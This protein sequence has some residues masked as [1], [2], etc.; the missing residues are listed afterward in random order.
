VSDAF[1]LSTMP[2]RRAVFAGAAAM[3]MSPGLAAPSLAQTSP[4]A[5]VAAALNTGVYRFRIGA[6]H[7]LVVSDGQIG[8]PAY[9]AYAP[10]AAEA[11]VR[12]ALSRNFMDPVTYTLDSNV[13]FVDTGRHRVLVDAGWAQGFNPAVG[14]AAARLAASGID[15][16]SITTVVLSH[17]HP[18][19]IGGLTTGE[20]AQATYPNAEIVISEPDWMQWTAES[21]AFG[22]MLIGDAFKPVFASAARR[23]LVGL[24][25][26]VRRVPFGRE[27]VPG[28]TLEAAPG[29]SPGHGV[30]RIASGMDTLL[31]TADCFHDQAFD[32]DQP[33]WRTAFDLDPAL[34]EATRQRI[35]DQAASD[36]LLLL[37]YHMPFPALGQAVK[38]S[39]S[40]RWVPKRW[41][42]G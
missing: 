15:P 23:N 18:D 29:H 25:D 20:T 30:I 6:F 34:A 19:H 5:A 10:N 21:I 28:I 39:P 17:G 41:M 32:L 33:N 35:L 1:L 16:A 13:L 2:E 24:R 22:E 38:V 37:G 27:V 11:D 8:L 42:V 7:A 31:Y 3:L 12:A 40:Y 9:P 4:S 14:H 26:R 36:R